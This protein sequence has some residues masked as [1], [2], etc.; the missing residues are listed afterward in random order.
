VFRSEQYKPDSGSGGGDG[1]DKEVVW[2]PK[3]DAR[4]REVMEA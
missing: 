3:V 2:E 4:G 1:D